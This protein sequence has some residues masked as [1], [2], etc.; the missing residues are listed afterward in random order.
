MISILS[1]I[2]AVAI[3]LGVSLCILIV[4]RGFFVRSANEQATFNRHN[5]SVVDVRQLREELK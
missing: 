5:V 3:P 4:P 1:A 2:I